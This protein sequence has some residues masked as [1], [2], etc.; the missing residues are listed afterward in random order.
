MQAVDLAY[1]SITE[2][3]KLFR[4]KELSPVELTQALIERTDRVES[5]LVPYVTRT[6]ERALEQARSAEGAFRRGD[7]RATASPLLGIP[8]AYKDIV[9]TKGVR[10]TAGSALH[11]HLLPEVDAAAVSRWQAAGT[12]MMGKLS[13]HEFALGLQPPE[14]ML[15]PARN[16]WDPKRIPGGSSSGSGA[17]LAAG[18]VLGAIGT[19]TGGSIRQPASFCGISGL[20]P[21]YGRVSRC[22][23]FTLAWSL[24]HI[25]PMA[26]SAE[27]LALLLQPLAGYDPDDP[28]SA[29][30]PVD[31]YSETL[32]QGVR[33]LRIGI[34]SNYFFDGALDE[35]RS[36]VYA[37]ADVLRDAGAEVRE[38]AVPNADLFPAYGV[39]MNT[40]AYAYH[41]ADLAELPEKYGKPLRNRLTSGGLYTS[42]EYVQAQRVRSIVRRSVAEVMRPGE[43]VDLLLNPASPEP[44]PE[45]EAALS[46]ALARSALYSCAFNMTGMPSLVIP[47]AFSTA[48]TPI[49]LMLSGRPWEESVVLRAGHAYQQATDWH[50]RRPPL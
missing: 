26:R 8:V 28:A 6:S 4:S 29:D 3:G 14:H 44:A 43:G 38:I 17:A 25:G 45:Y 40:E 21:T 7:E 27:D 13:T 16:P 31:H 36:A 15:R 18:L 39:I 12:V 35:V 30:M 5:A 48:G 46:G 49:G 37:A 41:A 1:L 47:C 42:P 10:T 23:V 50:L 19:D 11:E 22:G 34:P 24:D 33:G 20:K 32:S 9:M 2:A